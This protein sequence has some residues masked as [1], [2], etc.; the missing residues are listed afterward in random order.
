MPKPRR[1]PKGF[2]T[3]LWLREDGTPY[4]VGKGTGNRAYKLH[5]LRGSVR[6][7]P[8][9][10]CIRIQEW[11]DEETALAME[12]YLIDFYGRKDLGTGCLRNFTDGGEGT[13]G[14]VVTEKKTHCK[15]NHERNLDNVGKHGQCLVCERL[16]DL[17][18][19]TGRPKG[20]PRID[21]L[22]KRFG[23]LLVVAQKPLKWECICDCGTSKSITGSNLISGKQTSCGCSR[24]SRERGLDGRY[25]GYLPAISVS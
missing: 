18:R 20:H 9:K 2:Y 15:R 4:Y 25:Y 8:P 7:V 21:I 6:Q 16:R 17:S 22:G 14:R 10:A 19:S 12:I 23:N 5:S 13:S 11:P 3:Y 24:L 1:Y